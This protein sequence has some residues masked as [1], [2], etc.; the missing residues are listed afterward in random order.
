MWASGL[1]LSVTLQHYLASFDHFIDY[2]WTGTE[3][4]TL[5]SHV[6]CQLSLAG[7]MYGDSFSLLCIIFLTD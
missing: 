5:N 7:S 1:R 3:S 6:V 2:G 4:H